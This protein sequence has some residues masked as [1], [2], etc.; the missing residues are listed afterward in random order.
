MNLPVQKTKVTLNAK[1]GLLEVT[2]ATTGKL[3][4]VQESY[5]DL[6]NKE[7]SSRLVERLLPD[8]S[9]VMVE[10]T[11]DPTKLM[12]FQF[13]EYAPYV[14]DLICQKITEGMSL[15]KVC[16]LPGFPT[17]AEF[18][19]WK[20]LVP[21]IKEQIAQARK[22]RAEY[23]RDLAFEEAKNI[24]EDTAQSDKARF[25]AMM[26]LA[27]VDDKEVYGSSKQVDA[28]AGSVTIVISTGID[29]T[30]EREVKEN[31]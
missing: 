8:G 4:A 6:F 13:K 3:L 9:R 16:E 18:C 5:D 25:E 30:H 15:T 17:Y 29:R 1:T 14:V 26:K 2:D 7:Y 11:I 27:A 19:R 31:G 10:A 21:E 24:D 22:D 23:L 20:R 28:G 12:D